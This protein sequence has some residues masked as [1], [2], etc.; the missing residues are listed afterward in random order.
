MEQKVIK[1]QL[2][3]LTSEIKEKI[4]DDIKWVLTT[5]KTTISSFYSQELQLPNREG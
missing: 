1:V 2:S 4:E 5:N 3:I